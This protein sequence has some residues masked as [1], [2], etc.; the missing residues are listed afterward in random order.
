MTPARQLPLNLVWRPAL[1]R[2]DFLVAPCNAAAV[3]LVDAWPDWPAPAVCLH[4]PPGSGK[5]H[6]A[7]VLAT[8]T[9]AK[10]LVP[11]AWEDKDPLGL[12]EDGGVLV[13]EDLD[14]APLPETPLFHLLNACRQARGGLLLT[15]S[16]P[17]ARWPVALPDL[18]SRLAALP[19]ERLGEPDDELMAMVLLKL[20]AD[21]SAD[22]DPGVI[23]YLVARM[24]RS[25]AAV[26]DL[27]ERA[28]A[29]ALSERR[30]ITVPL[31]RRALEARNPE[32]G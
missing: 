10:I 18:R 26:R 4:G 32:A 21:R 28:D 5:S 17:P 14:E 19:A 7:Q 6:L 27:V 20:F 8:R 16:T 12:F 11:G 31:A 1:G 22:V 23:S 25:F 13:L 24:E 9:G 29:L 2:E 30:R 15:G 3:A